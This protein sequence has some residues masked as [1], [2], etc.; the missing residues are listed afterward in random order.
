MKK[1]IFIAIFIPTIV[2][3]ESLPSKYYKCTIKDSATVEDSGELYAGQTGD[4]ALIGTEFVVDK[5]TGRMIG[6]FRNDLAGA[7]PEVI[8]SGSKKMYKVLTN[9][10]SIGIQEVEVLQIGKEYSSEVT[11]FLFYKTFL[12]RIY[13]GTCTSN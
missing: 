11:T 7:K 6:D 5:K 13:S 9:Y 4:A 3:G 1:L 2:W 12:R 8:D 10:K